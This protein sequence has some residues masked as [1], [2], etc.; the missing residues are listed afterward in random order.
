MAKKINV[1]VRIDGENKG[2]KNAAKGAEEA[3]KKMAR[4][5]KS[6]SKGMVDSFKKLGA[7]IGITFALTAVIN[8]GKE[9]I[10]LAS[11]AKGV[12]AA[13]NKI[14]NSQYL[15]DLQKA[16]RGAVSD[17]SLMKAAV[18]ASNFK[19]PL[20]QLT[21]FLKFAGD[22]AISTGEDF[23]YL[24][25][26]I[27][28][29]LGRKSVLI[30]DNL[31]LSVSE[32][33]KEVAKTGDFMLGAAN[34]IKREME[35]SGDVADTA[36]T[37]IARV[38]VA[39]ENMK[40]AWGELITGSTWFAKILDNIATRF[41]TWADKD[42]SFMEKITWSPN[43][44]KEWLAQKAEVEK[45][46]GI[47][48]GK[49]AFTKAEAFPTFKGKSEK[50]APVSDPL[51]KALKTVQD[52]VVEIKAANVEAG[53][54]AEAWRLIHKEI[55]GRRGA[56]AIPINIP[57]FGSKIVGTDK[58]TLAGAPTVDLSLI[59]QGLD[60][61][62]QA[63]IGLADTFAGFFSDVNLGFQGMIDG[64]ITGIKRLVMELIAKAA[65]L[66]ILSAIF[67]G[68]GVALNLGT[69]LGG[70]ASK[71]LGSGGGG[72]SPGK[73]IGGGTLNINVTGKLHGKDIYLSNERYGQVLNDNS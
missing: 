26:S 20:E 43:E 34:V 50:D 9:L 17:L 59:T 33:N 24:V 46:F 40:V 62:Q 11:K 39:L 45:F 29:G 70:S 7:A 18:Q 35:K 31:G 21:V 25:E 10:N 38:T 12:S 56:T 3:T 51:K 55:S 16:T 47:M 68:A 49:G 14:A 6:T 32:I 30:L 65:F 71:L 5:V 42:L 28:K 27:V 41:K 66:A 72:S 67:P 44:Y 23:D 54:Q 48:S 64:V 53:K 22:R 58:T 52:Y 73:S 1:P 69:I 19:I 2:Y 63:L 61:S 4:K 15:K 13:F 37:K 36:A 8:F 60:E 57:T